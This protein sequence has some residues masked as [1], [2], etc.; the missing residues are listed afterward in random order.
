[1]YILAI[2]IRPSRTQQTKQ[3]KAPKEMPH[4]PLELISPKVK[5]RSRKQDAIMVMCLNEIN[6]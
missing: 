5:Q 4:Y 6:F 2:K 3:L 1:M